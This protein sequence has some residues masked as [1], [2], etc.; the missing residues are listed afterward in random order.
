MEHKKVKKK[1]RGETEVIEEKEISRDCDRCPMRWMKK[2][3]ECLAKPWDCKTYLLLSEKDFVG[4]ESITP[5]TKPIIEIYIKKAMITD[6][7]GKFV[8]HAKYKVT[9]TTTIY[10]TSS[11]VEE[12]ENE[13][14]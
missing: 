13:E 12:I 10:G 14:G 3:Q 5:P 8:R 9:F 7:E 1:L 6:K 11:K 2:M 4:E